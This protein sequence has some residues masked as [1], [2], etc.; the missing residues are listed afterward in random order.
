[1]ASHPGPLASPKEFVSDFFYLYYFYFLNFA[2]YIY[3]VG[4]N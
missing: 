3:F 2:E 4:Y 1:V